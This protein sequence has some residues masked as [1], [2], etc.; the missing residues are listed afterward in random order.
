MS[1]LGTVLWQPLFPV[2][3]SYFSYNL[4]EHVVFMIKVC[5]VK[6]R[7]QYKY[8]YKYLTINWYSVMN[9]NRLVIIITVNTAPMTWPQLT[10]HDEWRAC[11]VIYSWLE[12][13]NL[14]TDI[15]Q[16]WST[17]WPCLCRRNTMS[18]CGDGTF[19]FRLNSS[20]CAPLLWKEKVAILMNSEI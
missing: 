18:R 2:L 12:P 13:R 11:P 9:L 17:T 8:Q 14:G 1:L 3:N 20:P 15:H 4:T 16:S 7:V 19:C 10:H 5:V 6:V